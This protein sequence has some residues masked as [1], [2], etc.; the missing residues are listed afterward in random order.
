MYWL[1]DFTSITL[2]AMNSLVILLKLEGELC[3]NIIILSPFR[4]V[5]YV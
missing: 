5:I 3:V 4:L 1:P 2:F